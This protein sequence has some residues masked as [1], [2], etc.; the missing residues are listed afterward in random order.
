M[1]AGNLQA[2]FTEFLALVHEVK[3][4]VSPLDVPEVR[5][6]VVVRLAE[7]EADHRQIN[8]FNSLQHILVIAVDDETAGGQMAELVEAL[9]DIIQRLEV[10]QMIRVDVEDDRDIRRQLEEGVHI[11]ACFAHDDVAVTD[12][13]VAADEGQLAADDGGGIKAGADQHL[14]EHSGSGR[15]AVRT[16]Y[17]DAAAI[18]AGDDPQ[19]DAA[20]DGRD[21]LLLRGDQL[22]IILLDCGGVNHQLCALDILGAV[23]HVHRYAVA[24]DAV[25]GIALVHVRAGELKAFAVQDLGQRTHTRAADADEMDSFD[26]IQQM[27]VVHSYSPYVS[28]EAACPSCT[29]ADTL[30]SYSLFYHYSAKSASG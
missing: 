1:T 17:G 13:A 22:G 15:L 25:K 27:I 29:A 23:T 28:C 2:D 8:A 6:I 20:L 16:G 30:R 7:A 9:F 26:M 10:V 21:P 11:L 4:L 18:A 5:G 14:A 24:L 12:I 19:H 3:G